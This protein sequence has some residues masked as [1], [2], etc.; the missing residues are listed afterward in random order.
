MDTHFE[1]HLAHVC[2]ISFNSRL[3][4]PPSIPCAQNSIAPIYH[5][6]SCAVEPII[7]FTHTHI[8]NGCLLAYLDI[9][10]PPPIPLPI[11][12]SSSSS[13]SSSSDSNPHPQPTTLIP[14]PL[15]PPTQ[16]HPDISFRTQLQRAS[17]RS[18]HS[19]IAHTSQTPIH[20]QFRRQKAFFARGF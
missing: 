16:L 3:F 5:L 11:L 19:S 13:S 4:T 8:R 18:L 14:H 6:N 17:K 15:S 1:V 10:S 20:R 7:H 12:Q 2:R 9:V